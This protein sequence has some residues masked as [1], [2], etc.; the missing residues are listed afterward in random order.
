[1]HVLWNWSNS[2]WNYKRQGHL[3]TSHGITLLS[4]S[5][6]R[7]SSKHADQVDLS[8]HVFC[9]Y[10]QFW[11]FINTYIITMPFF[12]TYHSLQSNKSE[13]DITNWEHPFN[14]ENIVIRGYHFRNSFQYTRPQ[15]F[16]QRLQIWFLFIVRPWGSDGGGG[17]V[18]FLS[19]LSWPHNNDVQLFSKTSEN[20]PR[21][22]KGLLTKYF[23]LSSVFFFHSD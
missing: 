14:Q 11:Y 8:G 16:C 6:L 1:M 20:N 21:S 10:P 13:N 19:R 3:C 17:G 7:C 9:S 23:F 5:V 12:V 22:S 2:G 15:W 18:L 4:F